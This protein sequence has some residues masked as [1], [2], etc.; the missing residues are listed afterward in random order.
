MWYVPFSIAMLNFLESSFIIRTVAEPLA[1][2]RPVTNG[3]DI[4]NKQLW[5]KNPLPARLMSTWCWVKPESTC[6]SFRH[7]QTSMLWVTLTLT[8]SPVVVPIYTRMRCQMLVLMYMVSWWNWMRPNR[9]LSC[10]QYTPFTPF[11]SQYLDTFFG[12]SLQLISTRNQHIVIT[13]N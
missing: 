5:K 6:I 1:A 2:Q 4:H 3:W 10:I 8:N 7:V 13:S 11:H 12:K 9:S